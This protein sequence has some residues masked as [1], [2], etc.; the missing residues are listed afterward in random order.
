M[1]AITRFFIDRWQFTAVL[2]ALLI[3]LGAGAVMS[4]PK[5]EDPITEFPGVAV[6]IVL[7]G[8]DAAQMERLVAIPVEDAINAIEDIREIRSQSRAGVAAALASP[9][10]SLSSNGA[11]MRR[12]SSARW[13]AK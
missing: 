6:A 5:S 13:C 10:S 3:A 9:L 7:P 2:F 4:I 1:Q 11:S 8:A 12:T